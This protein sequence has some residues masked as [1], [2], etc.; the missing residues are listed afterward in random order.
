VDDG[1]DERHM[2]SY[3]ATS[4]LYYLLPQIYDVGHV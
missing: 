1:K 4:V 2:P 3:L